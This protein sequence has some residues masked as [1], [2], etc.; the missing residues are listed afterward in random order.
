MNRRNSTI[1]NS[2]NLVRIQNNLSVLKW[3]FTS[4]SIFEI[5]GKVKAREEFRPKTEG[6]TAALHTNRKLRA[7]WNSCRKAKCFRYEKMHYSKLFSGVSKTMMQCMI[8]KNDLLIFGTYS[9]K[10]GG[11][12]RW[13]INNLIKYLNKRIPKAV[14]IETKFSQSFW[15]YVDKTDSYL[16]Y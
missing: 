3:I 11:D 1:N 10:V 9:L 12:C 2:W 15:L 5:F 13:K 14:V 8:Q 7:R 6:F 4:N 16:N